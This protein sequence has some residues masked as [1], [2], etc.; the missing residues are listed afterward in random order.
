M[1]NA[2]SLALTS[3]S[4]RVYIAVGQTPAT[5][6]ASGFNALTWTE[7]PE[8]TNIGPLGGT[9]NVVTHTPLTG[10]VVKRA[11]SVDYG[12]LEITGA[13]TT[14][15]ALDDVRTAF[16]SRLSTPFKIVYPTV[17]GETD[18]ATGIVTSAVTDV[19]GADNILGFKF[20]Y[21]IDNEIITV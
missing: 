13:R 15:A 14:S 19:A 12:T 2:P 3:A 7:I 20:G 5:Y 21:A 16:A 4:T 18:F 10:V 17:L 8:V 11:G 9:T 1:A 6:D